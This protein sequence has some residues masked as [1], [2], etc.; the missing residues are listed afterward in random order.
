MRRGLSISLYILAGFFVY[1]ACGL[2]FVNQPPGLKRGVVALFATPALVLLI[3]GL[4]S[5]RFRQ[6]KRDV[7]V[8]LPS[9]SAAAAFVVFPSACLTMTHEL[10]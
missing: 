8:V 2:A 1:A 5:R 3:S 4:A 6:W 10:R 9:G 7:G